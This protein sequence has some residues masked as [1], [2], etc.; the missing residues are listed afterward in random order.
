M[1]FL[2]YTIQSLFYG[3]YIS[4]PLTYTIVPDY[5]TLSIFAAAGLPYSFKF[6]MGNIILM[7]H[8]FNKDFILKNMERERLGL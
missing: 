2:L 5:Q 8:L 4:F 7:K 1:I 3:F 6:I